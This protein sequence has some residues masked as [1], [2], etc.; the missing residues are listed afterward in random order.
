V[1]SSQR[2][3]IDNAV[4]TLNA[5][6]ASNV[7]ERDRL[8]GLPKRERDLIRESGLLKLTI[9]SA[10][11]G[12]GQP[13]SVL[14]EVV[15]DIAQV[16]PALAHVFAFHHLMLASVRLYASEEQWSAVYREAAAEN[17]FWGN[18]LNPRDTRTSLTAREDGLFSIDGIKSFCSGAGDSD[19]LIVSALSPETQKLLVAMVPTRRA[20]IRVLGDWDAIGQRQTDSGTV[21]FTGLEVSEH[22]LLRTPGPLG[23]TFASLRSCIAQSILVHIYQGIAEGAFAA[24][25]QVLGGRPSTA[26]D[27]GLHLRAGELFLE[28]ESAGLLAERARLALDAAWARG[29]AMTEDER[30]QTAVQVALAKAGTTRAGLSVTTRMFELMGARSAL[31]EPAFDRFFRNLRT[32]TLHDPVD[33]KLRELGAFALAGIAPKPGFYS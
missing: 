24:T 33:D 11:G 17:L 9:P 10:Y 1:P 21:V 26:S 4:R 27:A 7:V 13:L 28:L 22:E 15:R 8:G 2:E 18:A 31:R 20:G 5:E 3:R 14:F 32:H 23:S 16:D 29:D 30:A 19:R 6:L 12:D 25:Q